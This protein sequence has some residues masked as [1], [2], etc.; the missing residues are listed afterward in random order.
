MD[1]IARL[2]LLLSC[3]LVAEARAIPPAPDQHLVS[4]G[5]IDSLLPRKRINT[6]IMGVNAFANDQR[7]GT[8]QA[9]LAE[10]KNKMRLKY[11]R[12]LFA[13]NDDVQPSPQ[14][15]PNFAFY[16]DIAS[17]I[18]RGVEAL[19]ILTGLPSWMSSNS[20][21]IDGNPRKTFVNLWA[22]KVANR[23]KN[24]SRIRAFQIWNEPNDESNVN[25]ATL[26]I[27]N[28]PENY[29]EMAQ[30]AKDAISAISPRKKIVGAATTAIGQNYPETLLYNE[31][32]KSSG[33]ES[34]VD[35]WGVHY[36][37]SNYLN[38]V[39][40]DGIASF[41]TTLQKPIWVT[42]SGQ[43]GT[44]KQL[45]YVERTWPYLKSQVPGISRFYFYQFTDSTTAD[46]SYGLKTL[47]PGKSI[48][49]LYIYLRDR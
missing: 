33:L 14:S 12:V 17:H 26:D 30:L 24:R 23:Y 19:V 25:N 1:R 34:I 11:I 36:Y 8:V 21:W 47:T 5:L 7:F 42:E 40:P 28:S 3:L 45:A 2:L 37:G 6:S 41:L 32:L 49:D 31:S 39:R 15:E 10:V 29:V 13:W 27:V 4:K 43:K 22:T 18:P 9:Q 44:T 38:I 46:Q 20:N 48:S 16:D 35:I